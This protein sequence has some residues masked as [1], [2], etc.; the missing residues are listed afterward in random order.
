MK[1]QILSVSHIK[2]VLLLLFKRK[3]IV[4]E[5]KF[6]LS[7]GEEMFFIGKVLIWV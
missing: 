1:I 5:G 6:I 7:F 4:F 2:L 3:F